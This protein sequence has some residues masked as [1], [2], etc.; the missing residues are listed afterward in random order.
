ML[1]EKTEDVVRDMAVQVRGCD[2]T[3]R[4]RIFYVDSEG[5]DDLNQGT[6]PEKP[7]RSIGRVNAAA[8]GPGDRVCFKRGGKWKGMLRPRG[9]GSRSSPVVI[10]SY[11]GVES[12]DC[13]GS[14]GY[15]ENRT[16]EKPEIDGDGAYAAILL[17]GVSFYVVEGIRAANRA[18]DR[19]VRQ[20]ICVMG[21]AEGITEEIVIRGC[22]VLEV[23]GQNCRARDVYESMYWNGGIYVTMPGRSSRANHLHHIQ[24]CNNHIHDVFTSGI[25]INQEEDFI[26]DIHHTCVVVRGNLIERTGSDGIIVANSI[27]PL[28]DGNRCYDAGALGTAGETQFIAGIWVCAV[29]NALIQYNEVAR[30]R[31]F[32]DDGTAFD[33]DWGNEGD[34]VFQYNYTHDNEGGFWLDCSSLNYNSGYGKTVLR[35][36]VSLRDGRGIAVDDK[37]LP[38]E[39]CGN[40]FLFEKKAAVCV[41]NDGRDFTF[42][43]NAFLMEEPP[44]DEWGNALYVE[45]WYGEQRCP[46]DRDSLPGNSFESGEF[47]SGCPDSGGDGMK[48]LDDKW[49]QLHELVRK[50]S[51]RI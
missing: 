28:I 14:D 29:S 1:E 34:T 40:F 26:N 2:G 46:R 9:N 11:S 10:T 4:S 17:D 49:K 35:Y 38:A 31:L 22:E 19:R 16:G 41:G 27:S 21:K 20:G 13:A 30:T 45:N 7:W 23:D 47:L 6:C 36:N 3:N 44:S 39:F 42:T 43:H 8:F 51:V 33:T 25:R 18:R 50:R 48:W 12:S 32:R 37:G 5:G 24:I 15:Y